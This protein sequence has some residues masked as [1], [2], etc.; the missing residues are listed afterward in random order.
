MQN[1]FK[2][3]ENIL[4]KD[5]CVKVLMKPDREILPISI[6]WE[7]DKEYKIDK[8]LSASPSFLDGGGMGL[9]YRVK[10][11]GK[12]KDLYLDGYV[13]FLNVSEK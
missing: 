8:I 10:V 5:V 9:R 6:L 1:K 7:D 12:I 3:G 13:W 4:R 2:N 11:Y